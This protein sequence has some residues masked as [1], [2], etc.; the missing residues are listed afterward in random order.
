MKSKEAEKAIRG[1]LADYLA[2]DKVL[3]MDNYIQHGDVSTYVH[4]FNVAVVSYL[5]CMKFGIKVCITEMLIG[6]LLHD[7]YLYDWHDGRLRPEGLHGF[8]H[9]AKALRNANKYFDLTEREANIISS[10]M[11]P[12][13]LTKVPKCREA[14]IVGIADKICAIKETTEGFKYKLLTR[15][16]LV[17]STI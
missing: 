10:H 17:K 1:I 4:C 15:L 9:P 2:N 6:A 8:T 14:V 12:L 5:I 3:Q 7:F 11:F 16:N 13:T